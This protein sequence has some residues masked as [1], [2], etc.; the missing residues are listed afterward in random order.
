MVEAAASGCVYCR[1][2]R[3][4]LEADN[5]DVRGDNVDPVMSGMSR[6][7][8]GRRRDCRDSSDRSVDRRFKEAGRSWEATSTS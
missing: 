6:R 7:G 1:N 8:E 5:D 2:G 3:F 4:L